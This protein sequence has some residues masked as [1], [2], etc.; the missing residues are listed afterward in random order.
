[1]VSTVKVS[2][3]TKAIGGQFEISNHTLLNQLTT[4]LQER[5]S[6]IV[7]ELNI[8]P[9]GKKSSKGNISLTLMGQVVLEDETKVEDTGEKVRQLLDSLKNPSNLLSLLE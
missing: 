6:E 5:V 9:L 2:S 4:G 3:Q 8:V 7:P 1:M